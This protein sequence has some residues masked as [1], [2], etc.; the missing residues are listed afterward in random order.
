MKGARKAGGRRGA[1]ADAPLDVL[2]HTTIVLG[3]VLRFAAPA[4]AL[5]SRHFREHRQLG[6]RDRAFIAETVFDLLRRL[7]SVRRLAGDDASPRALLLAWLARFGGWN[8]QRFEAHTRSI[9]REWIAQVKAASLDGGTLA[10]RAE[11]PDWL[12]ETLLAQWASEEAVLQ[13]ARALNCPAPLDVRVNTLHADVA[14]VAAQLRAEGIGCE[15]APLAPQALRLEGKPALQK[16]PLFLAGK[17]EVQDAGSQL[18]GHLLAPQRGEAVC[19]FCAGAGGKTLHLGA[20]MR[21]TGRLYA[22]DISERRLEKLRPRAARAGLSNVHPMLIAHERDTR[23]K[24]LAGKMARVLVDAPCSGLGT[25]RRNPDLKWRQTPESVA[26][27]SATQG[28]ILAAAAKLVAP[29]GRLVY[30]TCSLLVQENDAV[31]DAFAAAHPEFVPLNAQEILARQDIAL[32]CGERLRL[33]PHEHGT[34]GFFAA[35]WQRK[36]A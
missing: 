25:L 2:Q 34:D 27:L 29:G 14:A 21:S 16:H 19:D 28:D 3:E 6:A 33:L 12:S 35:V 23:L 26:R 17:I 31:A 4:D 15:P 24:R 8:L 9:E 13:L 1:R 32:T 20:M 30:A 10:E 36:G 18:L 11:L 22:F 5:L 7:R